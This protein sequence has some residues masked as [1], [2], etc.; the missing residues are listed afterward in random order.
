MSSS[1]SN[2]RTNKDPNPKFM[3]WVHPSISFQSTKNQTFQKPR[4]QKPTIRIKTTGKPIYMEIRQLPGAILSR[5]KGRGQSQLQ[6][7][8]EDLASPN[9]TPFLNLQ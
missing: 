9:L 4:I 8:Q 3:T 1:K 7:G 6:A 5:D 2:T